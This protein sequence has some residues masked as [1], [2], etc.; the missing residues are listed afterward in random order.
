[1]MIPELPS[2]YDTHPMAVCQVLHKVSISGGGRCNVMHN[3]R[4]SPKEI[5]QVVV[6]VFSKMN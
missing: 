5:A 3:Y 6:V 1:M 2:K 4:K